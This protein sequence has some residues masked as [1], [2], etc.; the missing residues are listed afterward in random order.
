[1]DNLNYLKPSLQKR[2][3][4]RDKRL[5]EELIEC[6]RRGWK[7]KQ[8]KGYKDRV[9]RNLYEHAKQKESM[10]FKHG[11]GT[12]SFN[13]NLEPLQ[14]FLASNV[15]KNWDKLYSELS[16]QL[17][18]NTISG[19]HVFNHLFDFVYEKVVI[20]GKKVYYIKWGK[21]NEL[22][23]SERFPK[24][25]INPKTGQLVKAKLITNKELRKLWQS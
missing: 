22:R 5:D 1:M 9:K 24:F 10:K 25:Y 16:K 12:R 21:Y 11:G 17:N 8:I 23:S 13:D 6:Y 14:R 4:R 15:G 2:Q 19:L 18:K 7:T 20:D 3:K